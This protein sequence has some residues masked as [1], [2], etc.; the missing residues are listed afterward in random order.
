L[1]ELSPHSLVFSGSDGEALGFIKGHALMG[2]GIGYIDVHLLASALLVDSVRLWTE[3]KRL[4]AV[5][6]ELG[7]H[8]LYGGN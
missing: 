6:T 2:Q 7:G 5:A 1:P 4:A 3:D 8:R